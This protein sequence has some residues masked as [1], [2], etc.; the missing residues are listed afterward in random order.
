MSDDITRDGCT[1]PII[2][3][4]TGG[5]YCSMTTVETGKASVLERKMARTATAVKASMIIPYIIV[6]VGFNHQSR[7]TCEFSALQI[8]IISKILFNG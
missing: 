6:E 5:L 4:P 1:V 3:F 7:L 8:P 2:Y